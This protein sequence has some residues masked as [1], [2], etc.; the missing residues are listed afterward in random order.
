MPTDTELAKRIKHAIFRD[1]GLSFQPIEIAVNKGVVTLSGSVQTYRRK[2]VAHEIASS[3]EGCRDVINELI[4]N[5]PGPT[6]DEE[7]AN[8]VRAVLNA[9]AD[10]TKETIAVSATAGIV[11]L[12]GNVGSQW[13]RLIAEDVARSARGVKDVQNFLVVDLPTKMEDKRLKQDI[14]AALSHVR[15]LKDRNIHVAVSEGAIVL[16]GEVLNL[17]QKEMADRVVNQFRFREVLNDILV[18]GE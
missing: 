2:L 11:S 18:T 1:G 17:T 16:S 5:P 8:N 15:G 9:H 12:N 13:E 14:E 3:F 7:T 10:I 4:V 6:S